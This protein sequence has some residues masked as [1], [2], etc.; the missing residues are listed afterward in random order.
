MYMNSLL[1]FNLD[2]FQVVDGTHAKVGND[3]QQ[4]GVA[5]QAMQRP[6]SPG[7]KETGKT[8]ALAVQIA[9]DRCHFLCRLAPLGDDTAVGRLD[10]QRQGM[11]DVGS[12][13][14]GLNHA[15]A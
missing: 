2:L 11:R 9:R 8:S 12:V 5:S 13:Q 10:W 14:A 6:F 1:V 15:V 4:I 7:D 3:P